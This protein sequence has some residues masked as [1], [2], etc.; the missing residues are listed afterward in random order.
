MENKIYYLTP[1]NFKVENSV[2]TTTFTEYIVI[3]F[4]NKINNENFINNFKE[5]SK[6]CDINIGIVDLINYR[7]II[8]SSLQTYIPLNYI[9]GTDI[10]IKIV[11]Y[12]QGKPRC[13][14]TSSFE[15]IKEAINRAKREFQ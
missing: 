6:I 14:L 12:Y 10:I 15:N 3:L 4:T 2:L 8:E 1:D 11:F 5:I 7:S 9:E 13:K